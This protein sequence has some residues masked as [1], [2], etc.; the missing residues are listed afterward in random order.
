M[1]PHWGDHIVLTLFLV[2]EGT[3]RESVNMGKLNL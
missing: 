3:D 2:H 1:A